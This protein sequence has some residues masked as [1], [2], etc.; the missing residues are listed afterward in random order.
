MV[1]RLMSMAQHW[2]PSGHHSWYVV[3][4]DLD[5]GYKLTYDLSVPSAL[6]DFHLSTVRASRHGGPTSDDERFRAELFRRVG[7]L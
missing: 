3:T 7:A 2:P 6:P 4:E 1:G 5:S